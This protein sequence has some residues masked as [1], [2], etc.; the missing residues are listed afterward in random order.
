MRVIAI[1]NS[2][3]FYVTDFNKRSQISAKLDD[4]K[5]CYRNRRKLSHNKQQ[6][7]WR[8]FERLHFDKSSKRR[9]LRQLHKWQTRNNLHRHE[10]ILAG[11]KWHTN[12]KNKQIDEKYSKMA[13]IM[14]LPF[15]VNGVLLKCKIQASS[16]GNHRQTVASGAV[17]TRPHSITHTKLV[18]SSPSI[19]S[20]YHKIIIHNPCRA[21]PNTNSALL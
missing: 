5:M 20:T 12:S 19:H 14:S 21:L 9:R 15:S 3:T 17:Q 10:Q 8:S 16:P 6:T 13:K 18:P 7:V 11:T 1:S 2:I 4:L